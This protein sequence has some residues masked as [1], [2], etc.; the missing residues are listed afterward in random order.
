ME[1]QDALGQISHDDQHSFI[2]IETSCGKKPT[3]ILIMPSKKF[4]KMMQRIEALLPVGH[5]AFVI[6][7]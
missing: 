5:C 2:N 6:A 1:D 4:V 7:A 3:E